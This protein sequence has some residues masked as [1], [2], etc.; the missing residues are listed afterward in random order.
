MTFGSWSATAATT[1]TMPAPSSPTL[2]DGYGDP[3]SDPIS[4]VLRAQALV[5]SGR[6]MGG[7]SP[8]GGHL[9]KGASWV[10]A[11]SCDAGDAQRTAWLRLV[12][13][14]AGARVSARRR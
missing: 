12:R 4:S 13:D 10:A 1:P 6:A 9:V 11:E 7:A 3:W 5:V 8:T 2:C 14:R